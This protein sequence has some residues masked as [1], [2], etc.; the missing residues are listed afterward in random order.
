MHWHPYV[1]LIPITIQE[2]AAAELVELRNKGSAALLVKEGSTGCCGAVQDEIVP[3]SHMRALHEGM[4]DSS[5]SMVTWMEFPQAHHNDT[6]EVAAA[7]YWPAVL[8]F[9][10]QHVPVQD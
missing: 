6:Y 7:Q 3:P 1:L 9:F 5:N 2:M 10:R 8:A 4:G